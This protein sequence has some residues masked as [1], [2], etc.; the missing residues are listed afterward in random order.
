MRALLG[1]LLLLLS[2]GAAAGAG[3]P[4]YLVLQPAR[5]GVLQPTVG[6]GYA[7][8]WFGVAP[9]SHTITHRG[10]YGDT[11]LWRGRIAP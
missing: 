7:Y 1:S 11:Y 2:L 8:G 9:R 10:Y 3:T 6:T 5:P 4:R